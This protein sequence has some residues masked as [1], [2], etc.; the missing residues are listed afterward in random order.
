MSEVNVEIEDGWAEVIL[1]RPERKNAINGPLGLELRDAFETLSVDDEVRVILF[2]GS[3]GAFCSGLD[4]KAF[5]EPPEPEWVKDFQQIWRGAHRAIFNCK[6]PVVG[7]LE[8]FAI[9]GGAALALACDLLVV[10]RESFVQVGEAQIGMAAPYN[11]AWLSLRHSESTIARV[12][13]I[14]DRIYG[15]E[16][17]SCGLADVCCEDS[18]VLI[19]AKG[20]AAKLAAY[21]GHGLKRIK[22][23]MRG[24]QNLD[25][26]DWFNCFTGSDPVKERTKP[27][28]VN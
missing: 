7:A 2:R 5:N 14:G 15:E 19:E 27:T 11:L 9:N 10:G 24:A 28:K 4:L 21:P 26:D 20:V 18:Q 8:R 25:A 1:N 17:K 16:M 12:A 6:K 3:E 13:L 22:T 23:V